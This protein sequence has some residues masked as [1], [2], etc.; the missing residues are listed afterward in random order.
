MPLAAVKKINDSHS[1]LKERLR[2]PTKDNV[3]GAYAAEM[4]SAQ[5]RLERKLRRRERAAIG[6]PKLPTPLRPTSKSKRKIKASSIDGSKEKSEGSHVS[7][8]RKNKGK[9]YRAVP[10]IVKAYQ[11]KNVQVSGG[12]ITAKPVQKQGFLGHGKASLPIRLPSEKAR[13]APQD[14]FLGSRGVS[15]DPMM[16]EDQEIWNQ[17][18]IRAPQPGPSPRSHFRGKQP[19]QQSEASWQL[20]PFHFQRSPIRAPSFTSI[21]L[22]NHRHEA[23]SA[24]Q[25]PNS[26]LPPPGHTN[27]PSW[28][29]ETTERPSYENQQPT[30]LDKKIIDIQSKDKV[31]AGQAIISIQSCPKLNP[32][33]TVESGPAEFVGTVSNTWPIIKVSNDLAPTAV[34]ILIYINIPEHG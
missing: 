13:M 25:F 12:R 14:Q 15:L 5:R 3:N 21:M 27:S 18:R 4:D 19:Q 2:Q 10:E 8:G 7:D 34:S 17:W 23:A 33:S 31:T 30:S 11:A 1:K 24:S 9:K 26:R 32:T 29:T 16:G 22:S 20:G 6:K 28:H